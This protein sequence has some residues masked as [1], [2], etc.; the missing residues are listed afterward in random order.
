MEGGSG[1]VEEGRGGGAEGKR[2]V[3]LEAEGMWGRRRG[4]SMV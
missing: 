3:E 4:G 1:K 2:R